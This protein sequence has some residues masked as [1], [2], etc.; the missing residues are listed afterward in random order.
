MSFLII[1]GQVQDNS[2]ATGAEV[3]KKFSRGP[4]TAFLVKGKEFKVRSLGSENVQ[5]L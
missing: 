2:P 1:N 5:I 3:L 4:Y